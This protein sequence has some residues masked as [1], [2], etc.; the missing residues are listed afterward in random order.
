MRRLLRL[1]FA[2]F[3]LVGVLNTGFSYAVYAVLLYAGMVY[4][5]ANFGAMVAG[6]GFSFLTQGRLVFRNRD[7]RLIFRFAAGWVVIY[8]I[9]IGVIALLLRWTD[10]NAYA[11]GALALL[12]ITLISYFVQK[13]LVFGNPRSKSVANLAS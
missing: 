9:N 4:Y 13:F 3:L 10:V 11:A 8:G 2:R 7:A 12:P 1:E 5:A 6:V